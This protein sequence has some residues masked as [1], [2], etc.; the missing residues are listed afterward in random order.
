MGAD[1]EANPGV[2][3]KAAP[4]AV[5]QVA[6]KVPPKGD[7][8]IDDAGKVRRLSDEEVQ[9]EH[10]AHDSIARHDQNRELVVG[11]V[12]ELLNQDLGGQSS[13]ELCT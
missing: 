4:P 2:E 8:V 11:G 13:V 3:E 9:G 1:Q 10:R 5:E 12:V 7:E 6:P